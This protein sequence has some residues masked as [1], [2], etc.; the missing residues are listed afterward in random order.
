MLEA[1]GYF[2]Y[3]SMMAA[4]EFSTHVSWS[5]SSLPMSWPEWLDLPLSNRKSLK[6]EA[7]PTALAA[8]QKALKEFSAPFNP[9]SPQQKLRLFY[10]FFG[11]PSNT[12]AA[13]YYLPPPWNKTTGIKEYKSRKTSGEYGPSADREALDK[14]V[15]AFDR[16]KAY[17]LASPFAHVCLEIAD[18]NKSLGF[19]NC[20]LEHGMFR[21]SFG[22]VTETGRLASRQ[23]AQ[24][25]GSNAQNVSPKLRHIFTVPQGQKIIAADYSQIESRVVAAICYRLFGAIRYLAA[26]ESGDAHSLTCSM[27]WDHLPW[28]ADFTLDWTVRHGPFPKD[29]LKAAKA[30]ASAEFYRGK[31]MR[32]AAKTLGHGSNY[33]GKPPTMSRHSHIPVKLVEHFQEAYF[34]AFPEIQQWHHWVIE[35]VQTT[36]TITTL[37]GRT[38]QFFGRPN[39]DATIREAVAYEPQSVAADYCNQALLALHKMSMRGEFPARIFLSK[40]DEIGVRFDQA[41]E[42]EVLRI[43]TTVME[44]HITIIAPDDTPRT[45]YVPAEAESGWNLG[46]RIVDKTTGAVTNPNGLSHPDPTRVRSA[47]TTWRNWVL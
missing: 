25:F 28:P 42:E 38:R 5:V 46:R 34:E 2:D 29:M 23:N 32:D 36:A 40:H 8:F 16:S 44:Q 4:H 24:G 18:L 17:A 21:A 41:L 47:E 43:M 13:A 15:K 20:R 7:G 14:I 11:T 39:D 22:A 45:W 26:V 1:I 33:L 6:A 30:V 31:S 9:N 10:H 19:L 35:Q 12:I 27:V 37:L 3:Y